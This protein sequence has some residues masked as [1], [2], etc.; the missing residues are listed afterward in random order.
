MQATC[1]FGSVCLPSC[2][3]G[4]LSHP[5]PACSGCMAPPSEGI[6]SMAGWLFFGFVCSLAFWPFQRVCVQAYFIAALLG[7]CR[8]VK[9]RASD[10]FNVSGSCFPTGFLSIV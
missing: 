1:T 8:C 6:M 4:D 5:V 2:H 10:L 3:P 9:C 7:T